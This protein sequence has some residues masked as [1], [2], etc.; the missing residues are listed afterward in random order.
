M[1]FYNMLNC[2]VLYYVLYIIILYTMLL[3]CGLY[4]I[5]I[6]KINVCVYRHTHTRAPI[7]HSST[8]VFR[9]APD[10]IQT[11]LSIR[12]QEGFMSRFLC[13][14]SFKQPSNW[15][16]VDIPS[17]SRRWAFMKCVT[18]SDFPCG[19]KEEQ[20]LLFTQKAFF[21][22]LFSWLQLG[23]LVRI[24]LSHVCYTYSIVG[25]FLGGLFV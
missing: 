11:W 24:T 9:W 25:H 3:A 15:R 2:Y 16:S 20:G 4:I 5:F 10:R 13:L 12:S 19:K 1:P 14:G 23:F 21:P 7:D 8:L 22:V 6:I 17:F 18:N